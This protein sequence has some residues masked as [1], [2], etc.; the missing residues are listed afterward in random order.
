[1]SRTNRTRRAKGSVFSSRDSK[2]K[3]DPRHGRAAAGEKGSSLGSKYH[4]L[5]LVLVM[6]VCMIGFNILFFLWIV[7][8]EFFHNYL[9]VNAKASVVVLN[10]FGDDAVARGTSITS[11]RYSVSIERGCEAIQVSMFFIIAVLAWPLPVSMRRRSLGLLV[12]TLL[13]MIMNLVRIVSLYYTGVYFPTAFDVVHLEVWQPAF[14][15]LAL[16]FWVI[17]I[18]WASRATLVKSHVVT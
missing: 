9:N 12:G 6:S 18:W 13:L 17:W 10:L 3:S 2:L 5:R 4:V 15:V 16:F 7:P 11:S 1:M 8:S 14:I